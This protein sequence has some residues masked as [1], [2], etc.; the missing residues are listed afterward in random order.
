M[1]IEKEKQRKKK[2]F[3]K[4]VNIQDMGKER[5][6]RMIAKMGRGKKR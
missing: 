2:Q 6:K 3:S 1:R 5:R 4:G